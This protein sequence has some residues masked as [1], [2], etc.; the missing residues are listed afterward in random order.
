[1]GPHRKHEPAWRLF[2]HEVRN[3]APAEA[4]G[5]AIVNTSSGAGVI[6]IKGGSVYAA[7]K[8]GIIGLTKSAALGYAAQNIRVNAVVPGFIATSMMDRFTGCKAEGWEKIISE[9]PIGRVGRPEEILK[10][11][12][13]SGGWRCGLTS[14]NRCRDCGS[15]SQYSRGRAGAGSRSGTDSSC[16]F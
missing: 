2:V 15:G 14:A 7:A 8:H 16:G 4:G 13:N 12:G 10:G 6:G 3:S 5:G 9:D 11:N 1:M